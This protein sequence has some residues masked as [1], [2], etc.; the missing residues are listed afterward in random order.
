MKLIFFD[1][2]CRL[3]MPP[4]VASTLWKNDTRFLESY[5]EKYPVIIP[6]FYL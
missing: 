2:F 3:P 1:I 6:T 5:F 4:G